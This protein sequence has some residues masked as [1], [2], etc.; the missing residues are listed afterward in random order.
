MNTKHPIVVEMLDFTLQ[1]LGGM[2]R[3][4]S[5]ETIFNVLGNNSSNIHRLY[6]SPVSIHERHRHRYEIN[7]KY[8][9]RMEASG[10][11]FVGVDDKMERMEILELDDHPY[12][13]AVQFHPEYMS[14]PLKP[15]PPFF[16]L[17]L[18][19]KQKLQT[20]VDNECRWVASGIGEMESIAMD[21]VQEDDLSTDDIESRME[22][23]NI[24]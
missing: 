1:N 11:R 21:E 7:T 15:S 4:G 5:K 13:V 9:P 2:M 8:V 3:L 10:M 12:Y 6:G 17:I 16:G 23:I 20:F 14:R 22:E 19:A 18:A 24:E